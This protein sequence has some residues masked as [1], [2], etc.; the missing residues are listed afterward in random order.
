MNG[1]MG[2]RCPVTKKMSPAK[3]KAF[4]KRAKSLVFCVSQYMSL[5]LSSRT[6]SSD[7]IKQ[8]SKIS[9]GD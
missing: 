8:V 1:L 6:V 7:R 9:S 3:A 5:V 4:V 2:G